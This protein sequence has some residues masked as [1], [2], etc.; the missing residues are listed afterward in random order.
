MTDQSYL[1]KKLSVRN[2]RGVEK[3]TYGIFTQLKM[4]LTYRGGISKENECD[5]G[6]SLYMYNMK[7]EMAF[8]FS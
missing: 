1:E 4:S 8:F 3:Y 6:I 2:H 7:R 5:S